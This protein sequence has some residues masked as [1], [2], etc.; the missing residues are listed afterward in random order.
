MVTKKPFGTTKDGLPA[1]AYTITSG[2][3]VSVTVLDYGAALQSVVLPHKGGRVDIV[4]GYDSVE[5]YERNDGSARRSGGLRA[6]FRIPC[7]AS[8]TR[9]SPSRRTTARTICTAAKPASASVSGTPTSI[10][11]IPCNSISSHPAARRA[12]RET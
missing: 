10:Q 11:G 4:L 9:S 12:I 7:C 6:A 3:G 5:A 2:R 8:E 1:T